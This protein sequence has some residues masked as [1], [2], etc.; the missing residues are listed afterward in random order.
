MLDSSNEEK[1]KIIKQCIYDCGYDIYYQKI[2]GIY[3][4]YFN[5]WQT[6]ELVQKKLETYDIKIRNMFKLLLLGEPIS[7]ESAI[8]SLGR[9]FIENLLDVNFY[10]NIFMV[11]IPY[12]Q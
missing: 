5:P 11:N 7:E 3:N 9:E 4:Y 10:Y 1:I 2:S 8:N 12:S 6:Y